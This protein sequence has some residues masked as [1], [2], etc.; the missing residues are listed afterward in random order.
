M[1]ILL[2]ILI[3]V[4][5]VGGLYT[6]GNVMLVMRLI[7]DDLN[8][9]FSIIQKE[10]SNLTS[11]E[12]MLV[13]GSVKKGGGWAF[14]GNLFIGMGVGSFLQ[15]DTASGCVGLFGELL[16]LGL[17]IGGIGTINGTESTAYGTGLIIFIGVRVLELILPFVYANSVNKKIMYALSGDNKTSILIQPMIEN[18]ALNTSHKEAYSFKPVYGLKMSMRF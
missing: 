1:R 2:V 16:G 14:V 7:D 11:V 6:K 18:F 15:G 3:L 10:A 17:M 9:N 13:Y 8:G 4:L 5:F 12:R